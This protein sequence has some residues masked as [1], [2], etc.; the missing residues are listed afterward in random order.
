MTIT[1]SDLAEIAAL[2]AILALINGG[3]GDATGDFALRN[4]GATVLAALPFSATAFAAATTDGSGYASANSNAITSAASPTAG[5][6]S[7]GQFRDKANV[8]IVAFTITATGGGG[9]VEVADVV[10]P[11]GTTAISCSGV[12]MKLYLG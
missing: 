2:N 12:T 5:T 7:N 10:I 4:A 9:D 8:S 1:A 6:I 3:T 11:G